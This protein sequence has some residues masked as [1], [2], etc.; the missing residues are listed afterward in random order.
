MT[1]VRNDRDPS[2]SCPPVPREALAFHQALSGY[3]PT[4]LVDLPR[5]ADA[6]GVGRVLAK[7]E[8][9]RLGLPAFKALGAS[10]AIHRALA[11]RAGAGEA[12]HAASGPVT[13]VTA[14]DGNHGR[15]VA[16]MARLMGHRARIVIPDG[17]PSVAVAAIEAEGAPV[18]RAA[19]SYDDAVKAAARLAE[20]TGG[21]L[22]QDTAW[23]G[24]ERVPGW[25]VEGYATLFAEVDAQLA[26]AGL[27]APDL[28][29][30]PAG[31]G[32]LAQAATMHYRSRPDPAATALVTVEPE[33]AAGVL[34]S[35]QAGTLVTVPTR[36]TTMAGL[37][38]GTPSSLA[39]PVLQAGVDGAVTVSDADA[40]AEAE[41]LRAGGVDAGPCGW[42]ALAGARAVLT[43]PGATERRGE[44]GVGPSG[45]VL[46]VVTEGMA[47]NPGGA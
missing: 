9:A 43:G 11:D 21:I 46:L 20:E 6:L 4:P 19:G 34:A 15:A 25:I 14:T 22:L 33:A 37:N 30:V 31:V 45:T 1:W 39:W 44:L 12:A 3:Q 29:V 17:V 24:Y 38:C 10:W 18:E 23:P 8:S 28:V 7:N 26:D 35:L 36:A 32:S 2:W 27:E 16:R 13:F 5:I 42:A 41:P 47:A 40:A